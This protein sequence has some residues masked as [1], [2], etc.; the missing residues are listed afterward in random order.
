MVKTIDKIG[1]N[2]AKINMPNVLLTQRFN[3]NFITYLFRM[4]I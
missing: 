1:I 4:Q 2:E 3:V